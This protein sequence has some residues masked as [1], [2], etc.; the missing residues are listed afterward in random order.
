MTAVNDPYILN[1]IARVRAIISRLDDRAMKATDDQ[2]A[3][4]IATAAE[5]WTEMERKLSNR[6]A[7]GYT[8]PSADKPGRRRAA[9]AGPVDVQE[10]EP[11]SEPTPQPVVTQ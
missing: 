5:K 1:R 10:P 9:A 8:R 11:A 4:W 7:P 6:P 3:S 2:A